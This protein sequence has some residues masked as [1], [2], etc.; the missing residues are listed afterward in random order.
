MK[1]PNCGKETP[2]SEWN[3]IH[4]RINIYWATRHFDELAT[5]RQEHGDAPSASTPSFLRQVH[6]SAM[7]DRAGRGLNFDHRVRKIARQAMHDKPE[8]GQPSGS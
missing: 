8:P 4:C 2:E 5:I 3:C 7:D 1:C 6:K